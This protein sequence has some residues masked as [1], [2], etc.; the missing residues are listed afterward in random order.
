MPEWKE[1]PLEG[2]HERDP[3]HPEGWMYRE[4]EDGEERRQQKFPP[5]FER[6]RF[7]QEL[8][9]KGVSKENSS[10]GCRGTYQGSEAGPSGRQRQILKGSGPLLRNLYSIPKALGGFSVGV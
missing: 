1:N 6:P 7:R 10:R 3:P 2:H 9:E 8:R 5:S 4:L